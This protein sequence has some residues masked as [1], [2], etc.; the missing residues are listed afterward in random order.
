LHPLLC[1]LSALI[2]KARTL[3][4]AHAGRGRATPMTCAH[5]AKGTQLSSMRR[6]CA[7]H[8]PFGWSAGSSVPECCAGVN[9]CCVRPTAFARQTWIFP[10]AHPVRRREEAHELNVLG[11]YD[12]GTRSA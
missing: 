2:A 12:V 6:E 11:K 9:R 7:M 10:A 8:D 4:V 1:S 5:V 3:S